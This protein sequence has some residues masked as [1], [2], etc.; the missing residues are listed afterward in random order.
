M[1]YVNRPRPYKHEWEMEKKRKEKPAR[2]MRARARR[3]M[4][5]TSPDKNGN[6]KADKREGKDIAHKRAISKGGTNSHG[7]RVE[8]R[9]KNRSFKRNSQ[10][11]LVSETSTKERKKK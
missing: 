3:K 11:K 2:A 6:G 4:D 1:P 7:V 5:A 8:S 10:R 9:S